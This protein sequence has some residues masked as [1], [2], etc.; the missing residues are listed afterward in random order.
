MLDV[1]AALL[2]AID[3]LMTTMNM[4]RRAAAALALLLLAL[5][6]CSASAQSGK[7]ADDPAQQLDLDRTEAWAMEWTASLT[8]LTSLGPPRPREAGEVEISI[9]AGWIPSLSEDQRRLWVF[10]QY[11]HSDDMVLHAVDLPI[12]TPELGRGEPL[13]TWLFRNRHE[14]AQ[15]YEGVRRS[16]PG[17]SRPLSTL[18]RLDGFMA[19]FLAFPHRAPGQR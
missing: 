1:A 8:L 2:L 18:R 19:C 10:G 11:R 7:L 15:L 4:L 9:E 13:E 5:A 6:P 12:N 16:N 14:L 3:P 17:T